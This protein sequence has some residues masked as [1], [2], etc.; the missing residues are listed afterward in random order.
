METHTIPVELEE[1][2]HEQHEQVVGKFLEEP[3]PDQLR[4]TEVAKHSQVV[5]DDSSG[6][7]P[8][9]G[10]P[11]RYLALSE[12]SKLPPVMLTPEHEEDYHKEEQICF[13]PQGN[14]LVLEIF[15]FF[16]IGEEMFHVVVCLSYL[17]I[18]LTA[19]MHGTRNQLMRKDNYFSKPFNV[20]V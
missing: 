1:V 4:T 14:T 10:F 7:T 5:K 13:A 18:H 3:L 19:I 2:V 11:I 6:P 8:S 12:I 20:F 17:L 9:R 15:T 16:S